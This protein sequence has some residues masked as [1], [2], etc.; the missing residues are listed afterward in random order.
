[1]NCLLHGLLARCFSCSGFVGKNIVVHFLHQEN[2]QIHNGYFSC[3]VCGRVGLRHL[4]E[5]KRCSASSLPWGGLFVPRVLFCGAVATTFSTCTPRPLAAAT[6]ARE[7]ARRGEFILSTWVPPG[8]VRSPSAGGASGTTGSYSSSSSGAPR[9][10]G[11]PLAFASGAAIMTRLFSHSC[12]SCWRAPVIF[13]ALCLITYRCQLCEVPDE[14]VGSLISCS[15]SRT[16]VSFAF[17][18]AT[19]AFRCFLC[20]NRVLRHG[21]IHVLR[22]YGFHHNSLAKKGL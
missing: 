22:K 19:V 6:L 12:Q 9:L 13:F 21:R 8:G 7:T 11:I 15:H 1:M 18:T 17:A 16:N 2:Y 4:C 10:F 20:L 5:R 3:V 14:F